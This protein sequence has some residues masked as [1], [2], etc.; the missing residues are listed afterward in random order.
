MIIMFK[1]K[2]YIIWLISLMKLGW[3]WIF[4]DETWQRVLLYRLLDQK[5]L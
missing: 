5:L 2:I 4:R 1:Q 3:P